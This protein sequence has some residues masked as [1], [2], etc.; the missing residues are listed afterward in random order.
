MHYRSRHR[1]RS[2]D[3]AHA[4]NGQAPPPAVLDHPLVPAGEPT[5]V[6]DQ[7]ALASLIATLR[8]A[9]A[10]GYDSEFI[11]EQ[12]YYPRLCVLQVATAAGVWLIDPLQGLDLTPFW[13][14]LA[15][16][17]VEKIVHAGLQDLEPVQRQLGR[18]AQRVFDIQIAAAFTGAPYPAALGRLALEF[19]N[20][21]LGPGLKFS[22][23][24]Q[25]PLSDIQRRYAANDVR[26]LPLLRQV[27]DERLRAAGNHE[28]ALEEC[29]G[30]SDESL[31]RFDAQ[32]QRLR[33]RG[34]ETLNGRKQAVL[35][36][37]VAWRDSLARQQDL[38][39]R[40]LVPDQVLLSLALYPPRNDAQ[41]RN[42]R[43]LPKWVKAEHAQ[44]IVRAVWQGHDQ[45][46]DPPSAPVTRLSDEDRQ[47]VEALWTAVGDR[48]RQRQ[49][50]PAVVASK[51]ELTR[52]VRARVFTEPTPESRLRQGWRRTL[53][54][55][56]LNDYL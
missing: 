16:E 30:L 13:E 50:D 40:S 36:T 54:G 7:P 27:L 39:P 41:L 31:Y 4:S 25:R 20:A 48:C 15:D 1:S 22:Q 9:R 43:G 49:I 12:T 10:F 18:P 11:G 55:D 26:Y 34:V 53:L 24:D 44:A 2:H 8:E 17:Q 6:Q 51:K 32:T 42:V 56:L 21:A 3:E 46:L 29:R 5:L 28:W 19:A 45:P 23:W 14:L 47:H 38:P 33:L 35:R 52:L 37:L